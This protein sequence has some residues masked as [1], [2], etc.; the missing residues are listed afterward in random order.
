MQSEGYRLAKQVVPGRVEGYF[1][2]TIPIAIMGVETGREGIGVDSPLDGG[3]TSGQGSHR[4]QLLL[5]PAGA[6]AENTLYKGSVLPKRIIVD[7]WSRLVEDVVCRVRPR[8][9][10][11]A[12]RDIS[13]I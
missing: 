4:M 10:G 12:R 2:N 7:Q 9:A 8:L 13:G 1:V 6:L 3:S 5:R 11:S